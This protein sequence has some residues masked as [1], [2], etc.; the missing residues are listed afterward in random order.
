[1]W[2]F[3]DHSDINEGA[4]DM[5]Q[6]TRESSGFIQMKTRSTDTRNHLRIKKLYIRHLKL[7]YE[8]TSQLQDVCLMIIRF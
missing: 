2:P 3:N 8:T 7:Y 4:E 5:D 6:Y 1:M